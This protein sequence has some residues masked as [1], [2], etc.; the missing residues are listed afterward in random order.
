MAG[1][2]WACF[3]LLPMLVAM[4]VFGA[5]ELYMFGTNWAG[6]TLRHDWLALL[7]FGACALK[8]E[9]WGLAGVLLGLSAM[10]RAFPVVALVGV[11]L[12]PPRL[13]RRA[14]GRR[15]RPSLGRS[16]AEHRGA[17]RVLAAAA[18]TIAFAF[19][20]TGLLYSFSAWGEWWRKV[21]LLND[22]L[23]VNEVNLR[24]LVAGTDASGGGR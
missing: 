11:A 20:V 4:T 2:L 15:A 22:D 21:T 23:A 16:I 13:V 24:A 19:L 14:L 12:P 10:L 7:A 8:R 18:A 3:G 6:A 17:V 1:A 5:T 9:R